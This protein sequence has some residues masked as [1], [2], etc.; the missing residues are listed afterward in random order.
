[1]VDPADAPKV[2]IPIALLPSQD[3]DKEAV[4]KY[5]SGLKVKNTVE[6]FPDQIHGFMA[7]R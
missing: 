6:W 4:S 3:E 2:T 1:M 7:A 5:E